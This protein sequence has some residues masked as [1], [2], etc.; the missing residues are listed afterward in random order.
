MSKHSNLNKIKEQEWYQALYREF[1][2]KPNRLTALKVVIAST[3]QV[4]PFSIFFNPYWG[5]T[6]TLGTV[7]AALAETDDHPKGRLKALIITIISFAITTTSVAILKPYP[8]LFGIGFIS[9]TILFV[10]IGGVSERYRGISYGA[11]LIGIYAM[12]GLDH[13]MNW[14]LQPILL[15]AGALFY[16]AISLF[17]LFKKPGRLVEEQL[18]RGFIALSAYLQEKAKF[19]PISE[20]KESNISGKL[21]VLNVNVVTALEKC[22]EVINN[23][24][25]E[26]KDQ[27]ELAP[28]LQRF[29]LLQSLHERA[30]SSHERY[31]KLK[32]KGEYKDILEGFAELLHQLSHATKTLA[33]CMLTEQK[34]NHPVSIEWII[35]ALEFEIDKLPDYDKQL[36]ELLLHNLTRSHLSLKNLYKPEISTSIPRLGQDDRSFWKRIKDQ[37][38]IK[39]PRFRYAIRLS[40]C[41]L[42]GYLI[43]INYKMDKGEWIMLTSLFVCQP[44]YSETKKRLFER[45]LGTLSGVV[46]GISLVGFMPTFAGQILLILLSVYFFFYFRSSNYSYAVVFI[47]IYVLAG[48]NMTRNM[49]IEVMLPR[50][51]DTIIGAGIA[52]FAIRLL[53]PNWQHKQLPGLLSSA[54]KNNAFY[55]K[56]IW[57]EYKYPKEDD[58]SYRLARRLAHKADNSLTLSW[59]SMRVEPKKRKRALD[60][61]FTITYLNHVLLSYISA[62]GAQRDELSELQIEETEDIINTINLTLNEAA[63]R[64]NNLQPKDSNVRL[65]LLKPL[66]IKL[67]DQIDG[68]KDSK[69]KQQLRLIYNITGVSNKLLRESG[70]LVK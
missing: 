49:G 40:A 15:C 6:L 11:I 14:Y 20:N 3:V 33:E 64:I 50:V 59:Q 12:L 43:V 36:L 32:E 9:S 69:Q 28:F 26:V 17:L 46:I 63:D 19:F 30:A 67:R 25:E 66:L 1:W 55:L 38:T 37:L 13:S 16:G 51:I 61:A 54:L 7:A 23:Y 10:L 24:G 56:E 62:L 34:Y 41:F 68:L 45:I 70:E 29:M 2:R 58:Y 22:K 8:I 39:H 60:T 53:W 21:A 47:T 27:N 52:F 18:S 44:T 48:N 35:S 5:T 65:P 4:I 42:I 31:E 57:D